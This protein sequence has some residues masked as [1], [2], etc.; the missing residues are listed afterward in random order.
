[1]TSQSTDLMKWPIYPKHLIGI[2]GYIDTCNKIFMT[3]IYHTSTAIQL[4]LIFFRTGVLVDGI[5]YLA[6]QQNRIL[7]R[8]KSLCNS[9]PL[10][11]RMR[12]VGQLRHADYRG[13]FI[14]EYAFY[15]WT[16]QRIHDTLIVVD[17]SLRFMGDTLF[18]PTRRRYRSSTSV[19]NEFL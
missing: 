8:H 6:P 4:W 16:R 12:I 15:R 17:R 19:S 11:I 18:I 10:P 3:P 14:L 5:H 1:M 9:A 7:R 13:I 2:R